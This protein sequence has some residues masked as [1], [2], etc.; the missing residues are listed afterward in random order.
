MAGYGEWIDRGDYD[1]WIDR[2]PPAQ[3]PATPGRGPSGDGGIGVEGCFFVVL[4][5]LVALCMGLYV[6]TFCTGGF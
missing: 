2:N 3:S 4:G 6:I 5:T 1:A